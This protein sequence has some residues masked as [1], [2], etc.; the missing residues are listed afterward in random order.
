MADEDIVWLE[1][2]ES[3]VFHRRIRE[4]SLELLSAIQA[5]LVQNPE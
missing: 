5:D 2:V 4:L 3:K 1:F